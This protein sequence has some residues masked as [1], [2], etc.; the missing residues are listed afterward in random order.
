MEQAF[1]FETERNRY[2]DVLEIFV[3]TDKFTNRSWMLKPFTCGEYVYATNG[4]GLIQIRS[5]LPVGKY[6]EES[7]NHL[8]DIINQQN[9]A[10]NFVFSVEVLNTAITRAL[11]DRTESKVECEDCEGSGRVNC[12]HCGY[13]GKCLTCDGTGEIDS[14]DYEDS[15]NISMC[16]SVFAVSKLRMLLNA[17][18]RLQSQMIVKV[19]GRGTQQGRFLLDGILI[20]LIPIL[21]NHETVIH[22]DI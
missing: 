3:E 19:S 22:Y 4:V 21:V 5:C 1:I 7:P 13:K 15:R 11:G 9:T 17:A 10:C 12:G 8:P 14:A 6:E 2:D 18:R 16:G 20:I